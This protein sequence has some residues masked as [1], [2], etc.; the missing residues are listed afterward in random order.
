[1]SMGFDYALNKSKNWVLNFDMKYTWCKPD[2]K[3]SVQ[4]GTLTVSNSTFDNL[5]MRLG[6]AYY[7]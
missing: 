3:T 2:V 7:F 6:L 1:M 4:T 5:A